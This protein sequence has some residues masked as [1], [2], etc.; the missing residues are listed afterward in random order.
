MNPR[1]DMTAGTFD[2]GCCASSVD[3]SVPRTPTSTP[4]AT[5]TEIRILIASVLSLRAF[6]L[7]CRL[8]TVRVSRTDHR[9]A[10]TE[11]V[12]LK[13]DSAFYF[14]LYTLN[15][16]LRHRVPSHSSRNRRCSAVRLRPRVSA[17]AISTRG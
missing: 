14:V 13:A 11:T 7:T 2:N 15:F 8:P 1:G 9:T 4:M 10:K 12:P 3:P 5:A 16:E 6:G 17:G